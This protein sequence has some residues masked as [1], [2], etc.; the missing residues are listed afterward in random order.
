MLC[1]CTCTY[2]MLNCVHMVAYLILYLIHPVQ[3]MLEFETQPTIIS[4]NLH[5]KCNLITRKNP[6]SQA[7]IHII[8]EPRLLKNTS[9][10]DRHWMCEVWNYAPALAL[11][12][13]P[14]S[15]VCAC[16]CVRVSKCAHV[17]VCVFFFPASGDPLLCQL[18]PM[19]LNSNRNIVSGEND[20]IL[21]KT[22]L[23]HSFISFRPPLSPLIP[24][25]YFYGLL[26]R[27]S[28]S[29]SVS[30]SL[31]FW[32]TSAFPVFYLGLCFFFSLLLLLSSP[33][34][35]SLCLL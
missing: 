23:P 13:A 34:S 33:L 19:M 21:W 7:P 4:S 26:Y 6:S 22:I 28:P 11:A 24:Y 14:L 25:F 17:C 16:V 31:P 10:W 2:S 3:Q 12:A 15:L 29:L 8:W 5:C 27:L 18:Y 30:N 32:T 1:V 20:F 35:C 9:L